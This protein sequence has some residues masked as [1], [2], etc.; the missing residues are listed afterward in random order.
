MYNSTFC[1]LN[2]ENQATLSAS[3]SAKNSITL[4]PPKP[5]W[6]QKQISTNSKNRF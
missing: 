1:L 5:P 4:K 3:L 6:P 2:I